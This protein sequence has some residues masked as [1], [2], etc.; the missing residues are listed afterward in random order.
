[1]YYAVEKVWSEAEFKEKA[2]SRKLYVVVA[3][4]ILKKSRC[5]GE[6]YFFIFLEGW[7]GLLFEVVYGK[8]VENLS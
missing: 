5:Y 6:A 8:V 4:A 3:E 1:M 2:R 7:G